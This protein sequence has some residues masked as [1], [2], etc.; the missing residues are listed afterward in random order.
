MRRILCFGDSNTWGYN[1]SNSTRWGE[2]IRWTSRLHG[3]LNSQCDVPSTIIEE[4]LNGRTTVW[5]DASKP[6][7][8]GS[9]ALPMLLTSHRPLDWVVIML[10]TND[11]KSLF[12]ADTFWI[13]EG[14]KTLIGQ[15]KS[16]DNAGSPIPR[17]LVVSP[18][19]CMKGWLV[20]PKAAKS[21]CS[22]PMSIV[23]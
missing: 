13:G 7:R 12:P 3:H 20:F 9:A 19:P 4:G 6:Y 5:D 15:V 18:H 10:G 8:N 1:P 11:L 22:L 2:G 21:P 23:R 14:L 16:A 17:I